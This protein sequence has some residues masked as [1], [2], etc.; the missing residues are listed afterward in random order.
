MFVVAKGVSD[1]TIKVLLPILRTRSPRRRA[2]SRVSSAWISGRAALLAMST[3]SDA[4][5]RST[6]SS[7]PRT[8]RASSSSTRCRSPSVCARASS[9][10]I[11]SRFARSRSSSVRRSRSLPACAMRVS[12]SVTDRRSS[13]VFA[14]PPLKPSA[15]R[16][17]PVGARIA[18]TSPNQTT[19]CGSFVARTPTSTTTPMSSNPMIGATMRRTVRLYGSM[20][21]FASDDH[22]WARLWRAKAVLVIR[23]GRNA[24]AAWHP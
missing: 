7:S 11:S 19:R 24:S 12:I 1:G 10:T 8:R 17:I 20:T 22:H 6:S 4:A 14:S 21:T 5:S 23:S 13:S 16:A 15:M 3:R 2:A 18:D 9:R